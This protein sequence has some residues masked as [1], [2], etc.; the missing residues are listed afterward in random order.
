[1][2][3]KIV[4]NKQQKRQTSNK[5]IR[6]K[7]FISNQNSI[8][9][10]ISKNNS[11]YNQDEKEAVMMIN[12]AKENKEFQVLASE[13]KNKQANHIFK[14]ALNQI[15]PVKITQKYLF[16]NDITKNYVNNKDVNQYPEIYRNKFS[17]K[18]AIKS[19]PRDF[20]TN[21]EG[22]CFTKS[23]TLIPKNS[24]SVST[25]TQLNKRNFQKSDFNTTPRTD[26]RNNFFHSPNHEQSYQKN[27]SMPRNNSYETSNMPQNSCN[28]TR[29]GVDN[30]R[31][32][33]VNNNTININYNFN[34]NLSQKKEDIRSIFANENDSL[35]SPRGVSQVGV[36]PRGFS[37]RTFEKGNKFKSKECSVACNKV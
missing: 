26:I 14:N 6:G 32:K 21:K 8:E 29:N 11:M 1:M 37:P 35:V 15:S 10:P 3:K 28:V 7:K 12:K 23:Y 27:K 16:N 4:L 30:S 22:D 36:S 2:Q 25:N 17:N 13:K 24:Y 34:F 5:I 20:N 31:E 19:V 33:N 9:R 18:F